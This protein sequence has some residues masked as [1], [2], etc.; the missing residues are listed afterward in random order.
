M[1]FEKSAAEND[2]KSRVSSSYRGDECNIT[3]LR[4]VMYRMKSGGPR[5]EPWGTPW[6]RWK[7]CICYTHVRA[8]YK[9]RLVLVPQWFSVSDHGMPHSLSIK[10]HALHSLTPS[11]HPS[12]ASLGLWWIQF[13]MLYC[14]VGVEWQ[15]Y[16]HGLLSP[17]LSGRSSLLRVQ[18]LSEDVTK[19]QPASFRPLAVL[20]P[21]LLQVGWLPLWCWCSV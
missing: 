5:T 15:T 3:M 20:F 1:L 7:C 13:L 4:G 14:F 16:P 21:V 11:L 8:L 19:R 10:D 9:W 17:S 6:R 18:I 12:L 2:R